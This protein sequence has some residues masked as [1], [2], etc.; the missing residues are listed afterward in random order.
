MNKYGKLLSRIADEYAIQ[1]G[2]NESVDKWKV[3]I[4]YSLLGQMAL[5]SLFDETDEETVSINHMRR[6][7]ESVF[8]SY[9]VMYPE[10]K[11]LM[12]TDAAELS[13]EI[14]SIYSN[15]GTI[16]HRPNRVTMAA[17]SESVSNGV[18]FIRGHAIEEEHFVSGLGSFQTCETTENMPS[19]VTD[20]FSVDTDTL[21]TRWEQCV[22]SVIWREA[23]LEQSIEYLREQEPFSNGYW[24]DR[25]NKSG[26]VSILRSGY[27]GT[28][29]YYLYKY[30]EGRMM[31][32]QMPGWRVEDYQYRSLA[33][34]CLFHK[35]SLPATKY[36]YDGPITN[37][38]FGYLPPPAELNLWKLYTWPASCFGFPRDFNRICDSRVFEAIKQTLEQ[39]GYPFIEE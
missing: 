13:E 9:S 15:A 25:P 5:A 2:E 31:I 27:R 17:P 32:G 20:M 29:L 4:I 39:Q 38:T 10:I 23:G 21:E 37:I 34:A 7:I 1:R 11:P 35:G 16:Y 3:R 24:T 30:E 33:N 6:R 22:G 36:H 8:G 19:S 28:E 18:R 26:D 12:S 14:Y